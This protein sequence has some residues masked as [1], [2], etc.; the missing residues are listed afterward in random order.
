[1][2]EPVTPCE[3]NL[4]L[5]QFRHRS[6]GTIIVNGGDGTIRDVL[7]L[8]ERHFGDDAPR[9]IVLPSGKT[10][11]LAHDLGIPA[12][13]ELQ[14]ALTLLP[15]MRVATRSPIEIHYQDGCHDNL[16]GFLLGTGAFVRATHLAQDLHR[17]GAFNGFAVGSS[18]AAGIVQS[19]FARDTN[20][21][22][23]GEEMVVQLGSEPAVGDR[24]YLFLA[25][26]LQHLPSGI[27][28]FG[29][30]APGMRVLSVT[31]PPRLLAIAAPI[32]LAG[33]YLVK[34][35]ELGYQQCAVESVRLTLDTEFILDGEAFPG[36]DLT[37]KQGRPITFLVP[38]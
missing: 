16:R 4:V 34:L 14:D 17:M 36:G 20:D 15:R 7:S 24:R 31:A 18:L 28:P 19:V 21:W 32:L 5:A 33:R 22:R 2:A 26:T 25:S 37:I 30:G 8:M 10:N 1:M 38:Y 6:V 11:A 9:L 13:F 12:D 23:R 35:K 29:T 27:R 3:L